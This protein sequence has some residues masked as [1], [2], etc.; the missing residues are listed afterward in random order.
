MERLLSYAI[1]SS[2]CL[3]LFWVFF[4]LFL[5]NDTRHRR[6]RFFIIASMV[7]SVLVPGVTIRT[8]GAVSFLSNGALYEVLLPEVNVNPDLTGVTGMRY[9]SGF[10]SHIYI[11]GVIISA[12]IYLGSVLS[13][14][15]RVLKKGT[16]DRVVSYEQGRYMCY[17]ALGFIFID[18]RIPSIDAARMIAHER[19]HISALH[20]LDLVFTGL[21]SI[22]QWFNPAIYLMRR[23]L[24]AIHEY[25]ADHK[26]IT[27]GEEVSSYQMLLVSSAMKTPVAVLTDTF[28]DNSLL[29]NRIIM[30]TKRETGR[31]ASLKLI[32]AVPLS[33]LMILAFSCKQ[34][35]MAENSIAVA[36]PAV[37]EITLA[38]DTTSTGMSEEKA[39]KVVDVMP[40]FP[41]GDTALFGYLNRH[42]DYPVE[43]KENGIQGKVLLRFIVDEQGSVGDITIVRSAGPL[44]DRAAYNAIKDIPAWV[45]GKQGD[46]AVKVYYVI[47][48]NFRLN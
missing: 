7:I 39:F 31:S 47:P 4:R 18:N 9:L 11:T 28:S 21:I 38:Y 14:S 35:D 6:N 34:K 36:A 33:A 25:E 8:T 10:I 46:K 48:I 26:C 3:M 23:S 45:P 27:G 19:K 44:L 42:I 43:A 22:I 32:L 12:L 29:K 37:E 30:M 20:H 2:V 41:G 5:R 15:I 17:S 13:I 40:S 16:I 1:E 24:Q